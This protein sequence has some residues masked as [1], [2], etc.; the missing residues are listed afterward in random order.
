MTRTVVA[1]AAPGVRLRRIDLTAGGG[2]GSIAALARRTSVVDLAVREGAARILAEVR[3]GGD[4]AVR[5]A[6][7][8]FGGGLADGRLV[9][10]RDELRRASLRLPPDVH[11]ALDQA[12]ANVQRFATTQLPRPRRTAIVD[13]IEIE[14]R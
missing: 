1:P 5:A 12:I 4:A 7:Q 11:R 9:L 13:G 3:A 2:D 14:R 10:G 6:N 8:R